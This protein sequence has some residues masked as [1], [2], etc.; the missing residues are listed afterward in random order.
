MAA[1][2]EFYGLASFRS[3]CPVTSQPPVDRRVA[4]LAE[5]QH[6][7]VALAQLVALGLTSDAVHKRAAAGR[8][9]RVHRNVYAVGHACLGVDGRRM[10]AVLACGSDAVLSYRSAADLLGLRPSSAPILDV[11]SRTRAG[12]NRRGIRVHSGATLTPGDITAVRCVPCTNVPRT[13][14]DLAEVVNQRQ[15]E[16]AIDRAETLGIFDLV[17]VHE[18]LGRSP[19][20][21]GAP[22]LLRAIA[23]EPVLTRNE[24][25]ELM[26]GICRRAGVRLP[27]VN[28]AI[29]EY[30]ADFAWPKERLIVE[31][32]GRTAHRTTRAFE[33]D[34]FRDRRLTV[35]GWR[36]IRFT[37]RQLVNDPDEAAATLRALL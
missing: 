29:G 27:R 13:L 26:F 7:V 23:A 14:L 30:E 36:V 28:Y 33:H 4:R 24:L 1:G 17:A 9:H 21:C 12:R 25:E 34:R 16:R 20:R 2:G 6:G 5:R 35:A 8:L 11:S 22:R 37:W 15:I 18:L 31:T 19:G 32:D 3:M 10:A